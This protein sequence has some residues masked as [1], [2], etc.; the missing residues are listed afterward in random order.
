M[1]AIPTDSLVAVV[2]FGVGNDAFLL[3]FDICHVARL[4]ASKG[5]PNISRVEFDCFAFV[6]FETCV[7]KIKV[8]KEMA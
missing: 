4:T 5:L 2:S 7:A 6:L 3:R 1:N 8:L